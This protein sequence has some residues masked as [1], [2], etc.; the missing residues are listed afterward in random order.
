MTYRTLMALLLSLVPIFAA[1]QT[2]VYESKGE[3]GPVFSDQ[4][5]PGA[6][7]LNLPPPNVIQGPG[8]PPPQGPAPT[9]AVAPTPYTKLVIVD[10]ENG[11]TLWS[12]DGAFDMQI[13]ATPRLQTQR[14]D[15][16]R[17][18]IDGN[19]L[20]RAF[21]GTTLNVSATDWNRAA[22]ESNVE[23]TLQVIIVDQNGA[24][25][26]QSAPV[27]VYLRRHTKK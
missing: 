18:K 22:A 15:V 6:T 26:I 4:P 17:V 13:Q 2:S 9:P 20:S 7:Q 23:H 16:V 8:A 5:S 27:S 10:P 25:V 1:A 14:G 21:S 3:S 11:G 12:N 19:M 24:V